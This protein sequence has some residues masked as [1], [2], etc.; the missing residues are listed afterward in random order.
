MIGPVGRFY[1][2]MEIDLTGVGYRLSFVPDHDGNRVV[3]LVV[4]THVAGADPEATRGE[5]LV[6]RVGR[7]F[8][9][10]LVEALR[11]VPPQTPWRASHGEYRPE[12]ELAM[13]VDGLTFDDDESVDDG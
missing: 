6:L 10:K 5:S 4:D 13:M 3:R 8:P 12:Q 11:S 9:A 2:R 1:G 7:D